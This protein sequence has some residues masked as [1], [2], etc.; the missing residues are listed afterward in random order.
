MFPSKNTSSTPL[1]AL[2]R[3]LILYTARQKKDGKA[4]DPD[5]EVLE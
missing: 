3:Y 2:V 4:I 1:E 5:G